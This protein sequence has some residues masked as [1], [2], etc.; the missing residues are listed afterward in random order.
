MGFEKPGLNYVAGAYE[1]ERREIVQMRDGNRACGAEENKEGDGEVSTADH[2]QDLVVSQEKACR[3]NKEERSE[4]LQ[5]G[6]GES[7]H[8]VIA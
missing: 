2:R 5:Y 4:S 3:P 7:L 6:D 8:L 1:D